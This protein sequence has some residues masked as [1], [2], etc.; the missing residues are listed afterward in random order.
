MNL[1]LF[2]LTAIMISGLFAAP[3]SKTVPDEALG[4]VE[5]EVRYILGGINTK[6]AN[7]TISLENATR[8]GQPAFHSHAVITASSFFQLFM[9]AEYIADAYLSKADIEPIYSINPIKKGKKEGK[10]ECIYD[11]KNGK[12]SSEFARPSAKPVML[13][14]PYD[15][16][17]MD[18]LSLVQ[19]VRFHDLKEKESI[20]MHLLAS[21]LSIASTLTCQGADN[22]RF[23]GIP[24]VRYHLSMIDRGLM[25]N[26]SGKEITVWVSSGKDRRVL[27]LETALSSGVMSVSIK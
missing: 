1:H 5:Y 4:T 22:E 10:F 24:A 19:F 21:G 18:L 23:P 13:S 25:E 8:D 16:L 12:I 3:A 11:K 15:G 27:G 14:L 6:V 9:N 26:G 17:T 7:A 2:A 20:S